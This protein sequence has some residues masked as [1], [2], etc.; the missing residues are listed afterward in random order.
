MS[1]VFVLLLLLGIEADHTAQKLVQVNPS[2]LE[3][4]FSIRPSTTLI[5]GA[6]AVS[7]GHIQADGLFPGCRLVIF[8]KTLA[9]KS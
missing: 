3:I 5:L 1:T 8:S 4:I 9:S 2:I 7:M 6:D